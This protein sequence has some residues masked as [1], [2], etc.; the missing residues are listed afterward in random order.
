MPRALERALRIRMR[1][2]GCV[3]PNPLVG[4]ALE[5]P[6]GRIV[7]RPHAQFGGDHA[8]ARL[9]AVHPRPPRGSRLFVTLEP[10]CHHGKTPPCVEAIVRAR[11]REV[12]VSTLDPDPRVSGRGVRAL[13]AAGVRVWVGSGER[14]AVRGNLAFHLSQRLGRALVRLKLGTSLDARLAAPDGASQWITGPAARI[15]AHRERAQADA[16]LVGSGTVLAD[17]PELTVRDARGSDPSRIVLDSGLRIA[18]DIRMMRAWLE[19]SPLSARQGDMWGDEVA[20][21]F[22]REGKRWRRRPRLI[23][24]TRAGHAEKRLRRF[25]SLGWEVWELPPGARGR[26]SL[27]ELLSHARD[28]GLQRILAE[29]GPGLSGALLSADLVDELCVHVAPTV[30]GGANDWARGFRAEGLLAAP[31]FEWDSVRRLGPDLALRAVRADWWEKAAI[32]VH[33]T[34]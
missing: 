34:R 8:E 25:R 4:A 20:G 17:D 2:Q 23:L 28:L 1:A 7:A 18:P 5:F 11:V 24:V 13:R 12:V 22:V 27:V 33:R 15:D 30:L 19:R 14:E 31:R 3:S 16:V 9:L 29:A 21:N 26:V 6:D 10:C 32:R